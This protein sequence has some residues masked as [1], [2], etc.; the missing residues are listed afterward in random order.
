M[1]EEYTSKTCTNCGHLH[2]ALGSNKV[3]DCASCGVVYDRDA[4]GSRNILIKNMDF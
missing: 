3:Y 1:T 4:G 2:G